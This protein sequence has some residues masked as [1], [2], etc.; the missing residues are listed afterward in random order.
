MFFKNKLFEEES[1]MAIPEDRNSISTNLPLPR[2]EAILSAIDEKRAHQVPGSTS[3]YA[4]SADC[5]FDFDGAR[6][7][8][9]EFIEEVTSVYLQSAE[10]AFIQTLIEE[11]ETSL[12]VVVGKRNYDEAKIINN[13]IE[14]MK[15][16]LIA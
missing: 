4:E 14:K 8:I 11:L 13:K 7:C 3:L 6:Y 5:E 9:S 1:K 12:A 15:S 10:P 16:L 2:L